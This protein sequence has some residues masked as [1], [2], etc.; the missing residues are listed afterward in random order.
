MARPHGSWWEDDPLLNRRGE[1]AGP[2]DRPEHDFRLSGQEI[3]LL[4]RLRRLESGSYT[5]LLVKTT[6]GR[7]GLHSFRV[8]ETRD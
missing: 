1:S 6:R 2:A 5:V 8:T 4:E 7:D 3:M